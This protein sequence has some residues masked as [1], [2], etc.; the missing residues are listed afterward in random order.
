[1]ACLDAE[2]CPSS[3]TA[4]LLASEMAITLV[5]ETFKLAP[6]KHEG[7]LDTAYDYNYTPDNKCSLLDL[8]INIFDDSC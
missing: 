1:M 6:L 3:C 2:P 5:L 4:G 7:A 8:P